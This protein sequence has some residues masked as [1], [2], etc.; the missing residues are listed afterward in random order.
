MSLRNAILFK[1]KQEGEVGFDELYNLAQEFSRKPDNLTR[2]CR[3]LTAEG[4]IEPIKATT[5]DG[6]EYISAYRSM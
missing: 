1:V 2:R 4:F 5:K 6:V 3:E